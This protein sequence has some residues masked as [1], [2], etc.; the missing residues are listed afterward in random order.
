LP[1][2]LQI[3]NDMVKIRISNIKEV[4]NYLDGIMEVMTLPWNVNNR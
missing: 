2:F 3:K 4:V 1:E